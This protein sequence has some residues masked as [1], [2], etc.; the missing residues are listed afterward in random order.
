MIFASLFRVTRSAK[1]L[2]LQMFL[3]KKKNRS[4]TTS[5]IVVEKL[6]GKFKHIKTIGVSSDPEELLQL[7]EVGRR[8]ILK[9]T[10]K[11]DLFASHQEEAEEK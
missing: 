2:F 9:L 10:G 7:E 11:V 3:R 6:D 1:S 5:I 4:G 8:W